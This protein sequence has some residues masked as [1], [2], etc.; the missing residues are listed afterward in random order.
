VASALRDDRFITMLNTLLVSRGEEDM[1]DLTAPIPKK[2]GVLTII[3][4]KNVVPVPTDLQGQIN[5]IQNKDRTQEVLSNDLSQ[6]LLKDKNLIDS[7]QL[8]GMSE[9]QE[10]FHQAPTE[11]VD[12]SSDVQ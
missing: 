1:L 3:E 8:K 2:L 9:S 7:F 5:N 12:K 10:I 4:E 11:E 6:E